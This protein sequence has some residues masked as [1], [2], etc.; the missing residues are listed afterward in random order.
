MRWG[1]P[2]F[3]AV[4]FGL[5]GFLVGGASAGCSASCG[6]R[7]GAHP[8]MGRASRGNMQPLT[9]SW[10]ASSDSPLGYGLVSA[11][12]G[13]AGAL[14]EVTTDRSPQDRPGSIGGAKRKASPELIPESE[15]GIAFGEGDAG[16]QLGDIRDEAGLQGH[17]G[18]SWRCSE[19]VQAFSL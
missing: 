19:T 18:T 3:L 6:S 4:I 1:S 16:G 11:W 7:P 13:S 5:L 2:L 8:G 14:D 15:V 9:A 10:A 17:R 12:G